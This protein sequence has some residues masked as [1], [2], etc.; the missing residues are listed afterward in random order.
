[1][2]DGHKELN[3]ILFSRQRRKIISGKVHHLKKLGFGDKILHTRENERE[4][5]RVGSNIHGGAQLTERFKSQKR[6]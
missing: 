6:I 1:M 4:R 3:Q 2:I 5:L